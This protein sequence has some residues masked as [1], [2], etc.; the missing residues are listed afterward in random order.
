MERHSHQRDSKTFSQNDGMSLSSKNSSRLLS[1][2]S[3]VSLSLRS[4]QISPECWQESPLQNSWDFLSSKL[5]TFDIFDMKSLISRRFQEQWHSNEKQKISKSCKTI[6]SGDYGMQI[7]RIEYK[8]IKIG[9]YWRYDWISIENDQKKIY[10][11]IFD[12]IQ[13][14][15]IVKT[16]KW[17]KQWICMLKKHN[18]QFI[19]VF[20][21]FYHF[22]TKQKTKI[23]SESKK[24]FIWN[25]DGLYF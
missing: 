7:G 17:I 6:F 15:F 8:S 12:W 16:M 5:E 25:L 24:P 23:E 9:F 22:L 1:K 18:F 13:Y 4:H 11:I 14:C 21:I 2:N 10:W 19:F 3:I 20:V